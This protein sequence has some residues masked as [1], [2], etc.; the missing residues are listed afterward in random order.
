MLGNKKAKLLF[1]VVAD[2]SR[3]ED[4][5]TERRRNGPVKE[6]T[7]T[8]RPDRILSHQLPLG[9]VEQLK[10]AQLYRVG[11]L[12]QRIKFKIKI[13]HFSIGFSKR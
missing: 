7:F 9:G 13:S 1:E 12:K 11:C 4:V 3:V 5:S 10:R 6:T 2:G 8:H